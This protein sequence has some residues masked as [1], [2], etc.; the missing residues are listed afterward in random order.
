VVT[1]G[2]AACVDGVGDDGTVTVT[3]GEVCAGRGESAI[4]V[5]TAALTVTGVG[6]AVTTSEA[7]PVEL[8]VDGEA[9]VVV[10]VA[11]GSAV[12]EPGGGGEN[13]T[14]RGPSGTG[15]TSGPEKTDPRAGTPTV[16]THGA[17]SSN[18]TKAAR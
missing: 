11:V 15:D 1:T 13:G 17:P 12:D 8:L 5:G 10:L 3:A 9:M 7:G 14:A 2:V 16:G 18:A 6:R 4:V